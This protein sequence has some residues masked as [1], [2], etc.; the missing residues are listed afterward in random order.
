[1][2]DYETLRLIAW[3]AIAILIIVFAIIDSHD[4][5][6]GI[7]LPFLG[8]TDSE[9]LTMIS[10][11]SPQW[12]G[13][14]VWLIS[15]AAA[16]F[17]IWPAVYTIAFPGLYWAALLLLFALLLRPIAFGYR[18][19]ISTSQWRRCW[20]WTIFAGSAIPAILIGTAF[21]NLLL[22]IPF[23]LDSMM[24]A[25]YEGNFFRLLHPFAL[26]CGIVS[27][28]LLVLQGSSVLAYRAR[29]NLQISAIKAGRI[30]GLSLLLCL[31]ITGIWVCSL[32][33]IIIDT[34]PGYNGIMTALMKTAYTETGAWFNNY[35]QYPIL[36][37]VPAL[38]YIMI[39]LTLYLQ[40]VSKTAWACFTSTIAIA[41]TVMTAVI[42]L[43]PFV[44]PSSI[45]P[46]MSITLW[47]GSASYY[48]LVIVLLVAFIV[49]P[50]IVTYSARSYYVMSRCTHNHN[51]WF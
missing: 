1:M 23:R 27:L 10:Y 44:L 29:G 30:A 6:V 17:A 36:W 22:G 20:D 33:G 48:S 43:Y 13:S 2:F 19:K 3:L 25:T 15:S 32:K 41:A 16:I 18:T 35:Q 12:N 40:S 47:D 50:A 8:D 11:I 37:S 34:M 5:G 42:V 46:A 21:G 4:M 38:V 26:L 51:K 49:I 28:S 14:Q 39:T 31:T 45:D 7:L 24:R 9:R